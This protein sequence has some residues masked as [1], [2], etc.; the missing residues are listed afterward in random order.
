MPFLTKEL[1]CYLI[2]SAK[3]GAEAV[4]PTDDKGYLQPLAAVYRKSCLQ[5]A[6][7]LLSM[8]EL[9]LKALIRKVDTFYLDFDSLRPF[10]G[11]LPPFA[12]INTPQELAL[13]ENLSKTN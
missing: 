7:E 6:L 10:V 4:V 1:I 2:E 11:K 12:N 8:G 5:P 3:G 9:A 13:Y